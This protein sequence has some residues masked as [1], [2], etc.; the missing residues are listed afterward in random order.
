MIIRVQRDTL[1]PPS[2]RSQLSPTTTSRDVERALL[3]FEEV[4]DEVLASL[5]E[6]HQRLSRW[7]YL[8][9]LGALGVLAAVLWSGGYHGADH[10]FLFAYV[11]CSGVGALGSR[12]YLKGE[13]KRMGLSEPGRRELLR[14]LRQ[15]QF[16]SS[17]SDYRR[18]RSE[19]R[20]A[21]KDERL[22]IQV[23]HLRELGSR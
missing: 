16:R 5:L 15:L 6:T 23:R 13:A 19:L 18:R 8:A 10:L 9:G 4:D 7:Y 11:A 12:A 1:D 21:S 17:W 14:R 20:T 2:N 3:D 22:A